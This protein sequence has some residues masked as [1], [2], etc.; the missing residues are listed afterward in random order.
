[1]ARMGKTASYLLA[2]LLLV[3]VCTVVYIDLRR[4]PVPGMLPPLPPQPR[5][6][7][8]HTAPIQPS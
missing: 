8:P 6:A 2:G 7:P 4:Q 1:M 5:R 3:G